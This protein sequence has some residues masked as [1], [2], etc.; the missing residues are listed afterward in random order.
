MTIITLPSGQDK[1]IWVG[2]KKKK[3]PKVTQ[4]DEEE[5]DTWLLG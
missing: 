4:V 3:D 2:W 5:E 1:S